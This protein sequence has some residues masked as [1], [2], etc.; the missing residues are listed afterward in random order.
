MYLAPALIW[1]V[2]GSVL[3][4]RLY[5]KVSS[6]CP[7][8]LVLTGTGNFVWLMQAVLHASVSIRD[9]GRKN[10]SFGATDSDGKLIPSDECW[11]ASVG[12]NK[13]E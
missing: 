7:A 9:S 11:A 8:G 4:Q 12:E 13:W 1:Q 10:Y 6:V 5:Q 3:P 2:H